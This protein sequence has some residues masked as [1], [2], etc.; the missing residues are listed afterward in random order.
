MVRFGLLV[1]RD[2]VLFYGQCVRVLIFTFES[3]FHYMYYYILLGLY[4]NYLS[5]NGFHKNLGKIQN[6]YPSG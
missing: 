4:E 1:Y 2:L 5:L 3:L 6:F